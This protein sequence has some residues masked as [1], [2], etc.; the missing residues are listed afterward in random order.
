MVRATME[1][2]AL[3]RREGIA[4]GLCCSW[5]REFLEAGKKRLA[6]YTARQATGREVKDLR[7]E[8]LALDEG[9]RAG[10]L[11]T[12]TTPPVRN[13]STTDSRLCCNRERIRCKCSE[14]QK[15]PAMRPVKLAPGCANGAFLPMGGLA[16][17]LRP[18]PS[19][20]MVAA[21]VS[22]RAC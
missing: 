7:A 2:A 10:A 5:S 15:G 16:P 11:Q 6:G 14:R 21:G 13:H 9:E 22:G 3:C 4:Q 8:S 18:V 1:N 17:R 19:G 20:E 12:K